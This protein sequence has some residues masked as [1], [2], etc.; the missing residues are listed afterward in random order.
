MPFGEYVPW[1]GVLRGL[2]AFFDLPM[3]RALPGAPAQAPLM[4]AGQRWATPIC[5]EVVFPSLVRSLAEDATVLAT[6]S[7]DAWFGDS[8]GPVQHHQMARFRAREL[9]RPL[10]RVTNDGMTALVDHR[11]QE[12]ARLPRFEAGVLQG[13]IQP[14]QGLTPYARFGEGPLWALALGL[15]LWA[16]RGHRE[17]A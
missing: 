9:G 1:E 15:L 12:Q 6:L 16:V 7:N 2:I 5:Y 8:L 4:L 14:Q 10:L 3:A 17:D 13:E 11:G